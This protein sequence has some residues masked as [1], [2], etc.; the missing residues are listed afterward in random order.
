MLQDFTAKLNDKKF[1]TLLT[2]FFS[3]AKLPLKT[4]LPELSFPAQGRSADQIL[5]K[6]KETGFVSF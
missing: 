3:I 1:L 4:I 2:S 6:K 5:E